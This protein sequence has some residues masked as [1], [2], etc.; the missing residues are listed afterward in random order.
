MAKKILVVED[1]PAASRLMSYILEGEGYQVLTAPNGVEGLRQAQEEEPDLLVL[2]VM[3]PGLD[4]FQV[5]R[6][7]RAESRTSRIPV[8]MLSAKAQETDK[9][10]GLK[11]GADEYLTKPADPAELVRHVES[12]LAQASAG[13]ARAIA[14]LG[15]KGGVGTSTVAVNAAIALSQKSKDVILIDLCPYCGTIPTFMGLKP[16]H[17]MTE[18]SEGSGGMI[19]RQGLEAVLT[20]HSTGIRVLPG[21][22]AA[23]DYQELP[24]SSVDSLLEV[25]RSMADYIVADVPTH[26]SEAAKALLKKCDL[27]VLVTGSGSDGL[28][29]ASSTATLLKKTDID[30]QRLATVVVDREGLF[31]DLDYPKMKSIVESTID[32][33][34]LGI[35]PHDAEASLEFEGRGMPVTLAEPKRPMASTLREVAEQLTMYELEASET[36]T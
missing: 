33:P 5:C 24:L 8:L 6:R 4:G 28:A 22:Q 31:S 9:A 20:T 25:L 32:I 17:T 3:L 15:C 23:E 7:L 13:N 12:L 34:L 21:P 19:D 16:E 10:T 35:I 26:P 14:F 29:S 11:V 36:R 27:V 30:Q 2:D 18:L 1:D